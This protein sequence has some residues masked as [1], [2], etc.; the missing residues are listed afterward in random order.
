MSVPIC[1][2]FHTRRDNSAKITSFQGVS[3]FE[4]PLSG[5]AVA[6]CWRLNF[7]AVEPAESGVLASICPGGRHVKPGGSTL[8][9]GRDDTGTRREVGPA[10]VALKFSTERTAG[11]PDEPAKKRNTR[12]STRVSAL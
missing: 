12:A 3:L 9:V 4:A 1:N 6:C 5:G 2:R 8:I 11:G 7:S 10:H